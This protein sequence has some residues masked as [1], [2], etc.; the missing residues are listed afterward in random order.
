MPADVVK[1]A[2]DTIVAPDYQ[3]RLLLEPYGQVITWFRKRIA[4]THAHPARLEYRRILV[5]K[6]CRIE[7]AGPRQGVFE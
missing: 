6:F 1:S 3:Q 4:P 5:P 7:V 2:Q